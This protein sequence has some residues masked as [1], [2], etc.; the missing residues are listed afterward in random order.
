MGKRKRSQNLV[1][2]RNM[3][4]LFHTLPGEKYEHK[5]SEVL[6]WIS[7]NPFLLN[8]AFSHAKN[9]KYI[10]YNSDTG[11]WQGVDWEGDDE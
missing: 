3:P 2:A 8:Y 9:A 1:T 7:K 6:K 5:K 10:I 11:K 4:P